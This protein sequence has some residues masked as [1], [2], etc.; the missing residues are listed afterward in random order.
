MAER[1]ATMVWLIRVDCIIDVLH[2]GGR[3]HQ[4]QPFS[5][6]SC[7]LFFSLLR[8]D[9]YGREER[10]DDLIIQLFSLMSV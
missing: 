4:P 2:V 5:L 3:P 9:D 6:D 1:R 7:R 10:E 8:H